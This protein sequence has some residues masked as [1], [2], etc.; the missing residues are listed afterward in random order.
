MEPIA[1]GFTILVGTAALIGVVVGAIGGAVVWRLKSN[2][3][4]GGVLTA[5]AYLLVLVAEHHEDF[6]WLRAKLTWGVPSMT[7]A[8]LIC[9]ISAPWLEARTGLRPTRAALAAFGFSLGVGLLYLLTFRVSLR[10]PLVSA[11]AADL[12]L[13]LLLMHNR[14]LVTQ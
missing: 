6:Q 12:C 5:C 10:A 1:V 4:S 8:F 14:R 7:L 9:S 3:V 11:L 2:V 13:I